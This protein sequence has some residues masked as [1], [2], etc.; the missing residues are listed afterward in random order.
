MSASEPKTI[1][2]LLV[3]NR[4]EIARR[5]MRTCRAMGIS[6][7]AVFSEPDRGEPFVAEADEAVALGGAT[8]AESY[9]RGDAIVAAARST[10][11]DAIH[12]GYG[13]LAEDARFAAL[14]VDAGL[15]WI[16]PPPEAIAAMG[17]KL[18]A[19]RIAERAGVPL[20]PTRE[21]RAGQ[22]AAL[23]AAARELGLPLLVKASAGGGGR[24]M[25]IVRSAAELADAVASASREAQ[26]AFGD[27]T[28]FLEP[29]VEAPRH[30]EIQVFADAHGNV[31][32]LFE[33]ECSIQRRYQKII[34]E[35]PSPALD[36]EL[37]ARMGEAAVRLA[38]EIGYRGAGT[39]EFLLAPDGR[40]F[41]LEV[42]TRLQ[43]EHP[44]TECVTGL[45]LVR[46]QILV[47]EGRPLPAEALTPRRSGH[48]I[49]VRIYAEVPEEGFAPATGT[50]HRVRFPEAPGLRVEAGV[51]DGSV[52]GVYYDPMIAKLVAYAPTRAEAARL[53]ASAL[54]RT[55]LHGVRSNRELLIAVLEDD[56]FLAGKTDTHFLER[57]PPR[58]LVARVEHPDAKRLGAIAAALAAQARRRREAKVLRTIPSGWRNVSSQLERAELDCAGRTITVGYRLGRGGA[59]LEVD[60][61]RLAGVVVRDATPDTVL[62]EA[63]GVLRRFEVHQVGDVSWVDGPLGACSFTELPRHPQPKVELAA[64]SLVASMPGIVV[65]VCVAVGQQVEV[66]DELV[67]LEAMK[68]EH[69]VLAPHAGVVEAVRVTPGASVT[70][71]DVLVVVAQREGEREVGNA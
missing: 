18:E 59:V 46:L 5:V 10:G 33:R 42:N 22:D 63:D 36:D 61:E 54:R 65:R 58:E 60:G 70:A 47:A 2:K 53:L 56:E 13:F 71:G 21:V 28:V 67:V 17:S 43:V 69:R 27:D 66:G 29:Y 6:T 35:A 30:V 48:A 24:G 20:L 14:C 9:L 55:R 32:H 51:A 31:V 11:A 52:V 26:S 39:V 19:K 8:P 1:R 12:P 25:R 4:G 44:V 68:M 45:D 62:L 64:G 40:F 37:R 50:L 7:V 34:E 16:G 41:F 15:T 38:R 49:E 23:D 57:K 3:A